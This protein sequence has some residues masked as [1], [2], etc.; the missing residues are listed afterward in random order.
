ML[1]ENSDKITVNW[2]KLPK[3]KFSEI[4]ELN[5]ELFEVIS[6]KLPVKLPKTSL[7]FWK[8]KLNFD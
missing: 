1:P 5:F 3:T 2:L 7:N 4:F 6:H 8:L